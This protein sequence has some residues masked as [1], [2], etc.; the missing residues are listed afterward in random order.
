MNEGSNF[1]CC[2]VFANYWT[3]RITFKAQIIK[4]QTKPESAGVTY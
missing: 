1:F 4:N 2:N 3:N